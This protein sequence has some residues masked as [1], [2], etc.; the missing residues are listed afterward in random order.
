SVCCLLTCC[1]LCWTA[2]GRKLLVYEPREHVVQMELRSRPF[3]NAVRAVGIREHLKLFV[4]SHKRIN[5]CFSPLVMNVVISGSMDHHQLTLQ[6]LCECHGRTLRPLIGVI[7]RQAAV[8]LLVNRVVIPDIRNRRHRQPNLIDIWITKHRIQRRRSPT[9]PTPD[10]YSARIHKRPFANSSRG[11]RLILRIHNPQLSVNYFSPQPATWCRSASI[12][13]THH[14]VTL[15]GQHHVPQFISPTP[16]IEDGLSPRFAVH[17][18][19]HRILLL[20]IEIRRLN[21]PAIELHTFAYVDLE[22][23]CRGA[24]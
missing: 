21:H 19:E 6:I 22:K 1:C 24:L 11:V 20:W 23:L 10:T 12:V 8:S 16:A 9:A 15:L 4:G 14:D 17:I 18:A 3:E 13:D 7:L 5:Q 2:T